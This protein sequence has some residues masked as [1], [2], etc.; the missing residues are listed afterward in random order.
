MSET[1]GNSKDRVPHNCI[2]ILG[3]RKLSTRLEPLLLTPNN[4]RNC[5]ST[6]QLCVK[7]FER[8]AKEFLYPPNSRDLTPCDFVLFP[9]LIKSSS[10]RNLS[11]MRKLPP[12]RRP[13]LEHLQK[14][15]FSKRLMKLTVFKIFFYRPSA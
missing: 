8:N 4:K 5:E 12:H 7:L 1:V 11:E 3:M 14:K 15:H 9:I 13:V 2:K 10:S 6:S